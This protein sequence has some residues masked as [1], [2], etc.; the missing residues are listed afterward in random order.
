M[1][2]QIEK[3]SEM[4]AVLKELETHADDEVQKPV[5]QKVMNEQIKGVRETFAT[6]AHTDT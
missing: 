5:D 1:T 4:S 3:M 6:C 2:S